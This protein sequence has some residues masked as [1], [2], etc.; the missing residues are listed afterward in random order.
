MAKNQ[1][2]D[3]HSR[4]QFFQQEIQKA[5]VGMERPVWLITVSIFARGHVMLEGDVGVGKTTLLHAVA[6]GIGGAYERI[7]GTIDLMPNDLV[8]HTY[9]NKYRQTTG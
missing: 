2:A 1:L 9:I 7:E 3:W 6:R 4:A 5:V 8:Y